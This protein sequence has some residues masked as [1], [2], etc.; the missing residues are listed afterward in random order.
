MGTTATHSL[1]RPKIGVEKALRD[2]LSDPRRRDLV[3]AAAGW[4]DASSATS[5]VLSG[6]QGIPLERLESVL[7]ATGLIA[8][9]PSYLDW[10]S[11]GLVMWVQHSC[12]QRDVEIPQC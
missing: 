8:V 2:A 6:Q 3:C 11:T 9:T 5:R 10:L 12:E 7:R 1:A 4:K